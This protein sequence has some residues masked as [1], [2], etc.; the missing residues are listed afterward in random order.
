[1][2]NRLRPWYTICWC[3]IQRQDEAAYLSHRQIRC[4]FISSIALSLTMYC[5]QFC[6]IGYMPPSAQLPLWSQHLCP[7]LVFVQVCIHSTDEQVWVQIPTSADNV[8]LLT[9]A[10][11]PHAAEAP[12][13]LG[14]QCW[15][16]IDRYLLP[17][18]HSAANPPHTTAA[19]DRWDRQTDRETPDRYTEP[20]GWL[21]HTMRAVA[22]TKY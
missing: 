8:T 18:R 9:F 13:L 1:M 7:G 17:A 19:V 20:A 5:S 3:C 16:A 6:G 11:Q 22:V 10:A 14:V 2:D 15:A 12:L 4:K 21:P